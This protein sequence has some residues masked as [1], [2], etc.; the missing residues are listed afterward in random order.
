MKIFVLFLLALRE[1]SGW[2]LSSD[3]NQASLSVDEDDLNLLDSHYYYGLRTFANVPYVNCF[4]SEDSKDQKYDIA[5]LGAPHD[6]V[7]LPDL[8]SRLP[9]PLQT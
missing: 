5:V 6:T 1:A 2:Q 7:R 3:P 9:S 4:S 8:I